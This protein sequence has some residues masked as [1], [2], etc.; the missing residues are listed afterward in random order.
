MAAAA[1]LATVTYLLLHRPT[2]APTAAVDTVSG[3]QSPIP[4]PVEP[5]AVAP[6]VAAASPKKP[7]SVAAPVPRET[8]AATSPLPAE[9]RPPA[10]VES[11]TAKA[12]VPESAAAVT[13]APAPAP[14]RPIIPQSLAPVPSVANP[15]PEIEG[16]IHRYAEALESGDVAQVRQAYPGMTPAQQAGLVAFYSAG[17]SFRTHWAIQDLV[18]SGDTATARIVGTNRVSAPRSRTTDEAVALRVRLER[19]G[20]GWRLVTVGD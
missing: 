1:A 13:A 20:N 16:A 6:P 17:G 14:L 12:A 7:E 8:R 3:T 18:V 5:K 19:Q 4:A 9:K 10:L 11:V 15:V 2:T